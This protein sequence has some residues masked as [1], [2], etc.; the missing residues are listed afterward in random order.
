MKPDTLIFDIDGTLWD[1]TPAIA[2]GWNSGLQQLGFSNNVTAADIARV[3]GLP[4]EQCVA[5]VLPQLAATP[6]LLD[7]ISQAEQKTVHTEG[8]VFYPEVLTLIP[9]LS[10]QFPIYVVSNCQDWYL[11]L[12]LE[13]SGL[14]PYLSGMDCFGLS[15]LTKA[16]MLMNMRLRYPMK[17]P[18]Y[19][20]DTKWDQQ[21][22]HK[23]GMPFW[24]AAYGFGTL[25]EAAVSLAAFSDIRNRII[26]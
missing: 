8:G 18:V 9:R 20:G 13:K 4:F 17:M 22:A 11:D 19:I 23:A 3:A 2:V 14:A 1:A 12:F 10:E 25:S 7:A 6:E 15:R 26:S 16:E 5:R 24:Y 21:A